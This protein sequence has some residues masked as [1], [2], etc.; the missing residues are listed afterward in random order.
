MGSILSGVAMLLIGVWVH[1]NWERITETEKV[2]ILRGTNR[3]ACFVF[4][5]LLPAMLMGGVTSAILMGIY[6]GIH[7]LPDDTPLTF[8]DGI[9]FVMFSS[10][11]C[12]GLYAFLPFPF[13]ADD[14]P[15]I[16][17]RK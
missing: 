2:K 5:N 17:A 7:N 12:L 1:G 4:F 15:R 14:R 11:Y 6:S 3:G 10:V 16:E 9:L 8:R 13:G